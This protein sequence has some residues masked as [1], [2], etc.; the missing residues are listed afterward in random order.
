MQTGAGDSAQAG[1][2]ISAYSAI[3]FLAGL[4]FSQVRKFLKQYTLA[5]AVLSLGLCFLTLSLAQTFPVYILG[6]LLFGLGFGLYNPELLVLVGS[7]IKH[8]EGAPQVKSVA[9]LA[10][11]IIII[12]QS[13]G[14]SSSQV[15][16]SFIARLIGL[17]GLKAS[18][19]VAAG[20]LLIAAPI[21]A[22]IA[23]VLSRKKNIAAQN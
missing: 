22:V 20:F 11:S 18:W 12:C 8:P 3:S 21:I 4:L 19:N 15:V 5:F 1:L 17:E 23:T 13:I 10:F 16:L 7:T 6:S 9:T 14:Q 2:S